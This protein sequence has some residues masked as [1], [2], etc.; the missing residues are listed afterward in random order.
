MTNPSEG[1]SLAAVAPIVETRI[2]VDTIQIFRPGPEVL[3]PDT[4]EYEPGPDVI[5]CE[6]A[7]AVFGAG[8]P[9]PVLSCP[10][11]GRRARTT[12]G[13]ATGCSPPRWTPRWPPATTMCGLFPR[14]TGGCT[15]RSVRH[16]SAGR[17][18]GFTRRIAA[19][20]ALS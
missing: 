5:V 20:R 2:L 9:G 3:N 14:G 12:P 10:W 16:R 11:K 17:G 6:G 18:A 7:G 15:G 19:Q 8:G 13:T 4:G 1:L